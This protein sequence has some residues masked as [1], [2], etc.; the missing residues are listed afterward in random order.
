MKP[1]IKFEDGLLKVN[2]AYVLDVDVDGKQSAKIAVQVEL[3]PTEVI[4]EI[5][6]KDLPWLEAILA[7]IKA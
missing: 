2:A 1:E 3:N 6:K 7:G 5:A 4:S